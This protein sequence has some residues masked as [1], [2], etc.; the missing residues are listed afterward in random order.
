LLL[1]LGRV[2]AAR[3]LYTEAI[4]AGN[5]TVAWQLANKI[6]PTDT[7][8]IDVTPIRHKAA[9]GDRQAVRGLAWLAATN[10]HPDH[11]LEVL[12][13]ALHRG[14]TEAITPLATILRHLGRTDDA[15][16]LRKF[17]IEPTGEITH[18]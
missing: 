1:A 12:F 17:G 9:T 10:G 6:D 15:H 8:T 13:D 3:R 16:H 2:E 11:A 5:G 4:E 14:V 18:Q 7:L